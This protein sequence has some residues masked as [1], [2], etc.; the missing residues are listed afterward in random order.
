MFVTIDILKRAGA[1]QEGIDWMNKH[2][3][4]GAEMVDII[5]HKE[6]PLSLLHWGKD[7]LDY[8][9]AEEEAYW[10]RVG[11]DKTSRPYCYSSEKV[12]K[13]YMISKSSNVTNSQYV[14]NSRKVIDSDTVTNSI[15]VQS[16]EFIY[17][18]K[19]IQ[20]SARV[21]DGRNVSNSSNIIGSTYIID[22]TNVVDSS[23]VTNSS[24]VY[25][26]AK[27]SNNVNNSYFIA[28]CQNVEN[29]LFCYG[30]ED[31]KNM[32]FNKPISTQSFENI[33]RQLQQ[34]LK[35]WEP[36]LIKGHWVGEIF[37]I[38]TP[39]RERN[40][41]VWFANLPED[42][43]EWVQTLPGFDASVFYAITYSKELI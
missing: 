35:E 3:P 36:K 38:E 30:L 33:K 6:M 19:F 28:N 9:K 21:I 25:G 43:Y 2:Y 4:N 26:F 8:S 5:Q 22:S 7:R 14:T 18:S 31:A 10:E 41:S 39:L 40:I 27:Q 17:S 20:D 34:F 24:V 23:N 15:Q 29:C 11:V 1:C 16:G 42:F 37:P 32:L 13:G 12:E